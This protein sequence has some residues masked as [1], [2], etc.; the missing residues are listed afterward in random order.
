M[1][2]SD[3]EKELIPE[4]ETI[5]LPILLFL[6]ALL[7]SSVGH[8]GAS[9]YLA[10]MA[11]VGIAPEIM[12]PSALFLNILVSLIATYK[13]YKAGSFSWS[14]FIP[15][16]ITSIPMAFIGGRLSLPEEIYRPLVGAVLLFAA[17]N[18]VKTARNHSEYQVKEPS[19]LFISISGGLL[20]FLSGLTGVGGGIFL[21]PLMLFLHWAP[22]KVVSGVAAGFILVNSISGLLGVV[23][24]QPSINPSMFIWAVAVI[25]G[26]FIG[27]EFGS[28]RLGNHI[29]LYILAV[30]MLFGGLRLFFM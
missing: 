20:G 25:L 10:I 8:A 19:K 15:L 21:S 12:R 4:I 9:G 26:G 23:S 2:E 28:K 16:V 11:L 18:L 3:Q 13:F 7:Y 1:F 22:I 14:I 29:I 24:V 17:W 6:V 5:I 27:A 30:V